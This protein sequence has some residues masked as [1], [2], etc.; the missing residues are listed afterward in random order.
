MAKEISYFQYNDLLNEYFFDGKFANKPIYLDLETEVLAS[1]GEKI[2]ENSIY[3]EKNLPRVV[4]NNFN[5]NSKNAYNWY[6]QKYYQ[7]QREEREKPPPFTAF[8]CVLSMSA[9]SMRDGKRFGGNNFYD[10]Y[11]ELLNISDPTSKLN[12]KSTEAM[13]DTVILWRALNRWL[14]FTDYQYGMPTAKE[15]GPKRY[16]S[17]PMSQALVRDQDRKNLNLMFENKQLNSNQFI[18]K[19]EMSLILDDW[20]NTSY[21][22]KSLVS[23]WKEKPLKEKVVD[24][25]LESF[26]NWDGGS[27]NASGQKNLLLK[28]FNLILRKTN[29]NF[30]EFLTVGFAIQDA[31]IT[32]VSKLTIEKSKNRSPNIFEQLD[33]ELCLRPEG[34]GSNISYL[35][36][37]SININTMLV[38]NF[39]LLSDDKTKIFNFQ[40]LPFY[41]FVKSYDGIYY[42]QTRQVTLGLKHIILCQSQNWTTKIKHF[43]E[44]NSDNKFKLS[45]S[46]QLTGMPL[47]WDLF[48]DVEVIRTPESPSPHLQT[49][50]PNTSEAI[51]RTNGGLELA[52]NTWHADCPPTVEAI[53]PNKDFE[54]EIVN[55]L[56]KPEILFHE[57]LSSN[58][59][60]ELTF[61]D[62]LDQ[63]NLIIKLKCPSQ[64]LEK[65]INFR[66]SDK[67]KFLKLKKYD[68]SCNLMDPFSFFT[69]H[70]KRI[71]SIE[72]NTDL[73]RLNGYSIS[74][75]DLQI[76]DNTNDLNEIEIF[77]DDENQLI[78]GNT[79]YINSDLIPIYKNQKVE[80]LVGNSCIVSGV[81]TWKIPFGAK[82]LTSLK[83]IRAKCTICGAINFF[84]GKKVKRSV[85]AS[86][87]NVAS[88]EKTIPKNGTWK[89]ENISS[90]LDINKS[91]IELNLKNKLDGKNTEIIF[92]ALCYLGYGS[93]HTFKKIIKLFTESDLDVWNYYKEFNDL[94][95]I[96]FE[97]DSINLKPISWEI[98]QP[99]LIKLPDNSIYFIGFRNLK[100]ISELKEMFSLL[101]NVKYKTYL[102][103]KNNFAVHKWH[104]ISNID[105]DNLSNIRDLNNRKIIVIDDPA[106]EIARTSVK[107]SDVFLTLPSINIGEVEDLKKF[108]PSNGKWKD[109]EDCHSSG[110]F[111]AD[112]FGNKHFYK[113][114]DGEARIGT[115]EIVKLL[116][117]LDH[118]ITF[119]RYDEVTKKFTSSI[120]CEVPGLLR[121]ALVA[122]SGDLPNIQSGKLEYKN[123]SLNLAKM[124]Y[125]R[126]QN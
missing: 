25:A 62:N 86:T 18:S 3:V 32:E 59:E 123:V 122:S 21:G 115:Y 124:I 51:L 112:I 111:K 48:E 119:Y 90:D 66:S 33:D 54:L 22:A 65:S 12:I 120:G 92:D 55:D 27:T 108:D 31:S 8:L 117:A 77:M 103:G 85:L 106:P 53:F 38:N 11:A 93:F 100:M 101:D 14:K 98:T 29:R 42:N 7:W 39:N 79:E 24:A 44:D 126:L 47:D 35:F 34:D 61:I 78:E 16:I 99:T 17:W 43:L 107:L 81:H 88:L 57:Q 37:K 40:A 13:Q 20:L 104:N 114:L 19:S 9:E 45:N 49:L 91:D 2:G 46:K 118:G 102:T 64:Q 26:A 83:P 116:A 71:S 96:D 70:C 75:E 95:H 80:N 105:L 30:R 28:N 41:I 15:V 97:L 74:N 68:L 89:K 56:D 6:F 69:G 84:E 63:K 113:N 125:T 10:R 76:K 121:R 109:C 67:P 1:I 73:G 60:K 50:I 87:L 5:L 94:G 52:S 82:A 36:P 58:F 4:A 72:T 23:I 110:A